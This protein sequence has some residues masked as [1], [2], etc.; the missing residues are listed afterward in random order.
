MQHKEFDN[1]ESSIDFLTTLK[2]TQITLVH[3]NKN[4]DITTHNIIYKITISSYVT[5]Y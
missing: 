1:N 4:Y 3:K 2:K 5:S